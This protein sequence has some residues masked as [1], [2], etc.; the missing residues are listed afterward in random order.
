MALQDVHKALIGIGFGEY[1]ARAYCALLSHSPANGYEVS[2]HSGVPRA[3]VYECLEKL[4]ARGAA[5]RVESTDAKAQVFAPTDPQVLFD[6]I[7]HELKNN[8]N[9]ARKEIKQYRENPQLV[10]AFWRVIS[11]QDLIARAQ[12]LIEEAEETLHVALW[13]D[14]F[15]AVFP[16]LEAALQ[17]GARMALILYSPHRHLRKLQE[18][19]GGA[20]CH[21]RSKRKA[22]PLL[23]RQFVLVADSAKC[24]TGSVFPDDKVEGAFTM[25]RGLVT[26]ALDLVNHEIYVERM[27]DEVGGPVVKRYGK[28][29]DGLNSFDSVKPK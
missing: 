4:V 2:R 9:C 22:M 13:P 14:E 24:I 11:T 28:T 21:C 27:L 23:G 1:E 5:A 15:Q 25:N 20:V 18:L 17:R 8:M 19:G 12:V 10:E 16:M 6:N 29:L 7:E 3:K 26:N